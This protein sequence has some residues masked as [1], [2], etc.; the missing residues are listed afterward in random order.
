MDAAREAFLAGCRASRACLSRGI[1]KRLLSILSFA[2]TGVDAEL[3][4]MRLDSLG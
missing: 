1:S 2:V 3:L 4:L